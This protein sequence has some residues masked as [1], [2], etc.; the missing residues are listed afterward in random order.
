[1]MQWNVDENQS[2]EPSETCGLADSSPG[3]ACWFNQ[4]SSNDTSV[5]SQKCVLFIYLNPLFNL[6]S[7]MR[8]TSHVQWWATQD[9]PTEQQEAT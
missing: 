9:A 3:A 7:Q 8:T 2:G 1:M 4:S 5:A 6:M